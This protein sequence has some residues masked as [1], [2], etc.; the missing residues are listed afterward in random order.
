MKEPMISIIIPAYNAARTLPVLI[1]SVMEQP[2][3]NIEVIVVDDGSK[4]KTSEVVN[5][6]VIKNKRVILLS[7]SNQGVSAARNAG[8]RMARGEYMVFLDADDSIKTSMIEK[9]VNAVQ[10][11]RDSLVVCGVM[12]GDKEVLPSC[13][14]L[15]SRDVKE[16]VVAAILKN[17]L[18]Y[19][20]CN[21]IFVSSVIKEN[22]I[23]F[24]TKVKYGEDLIFNL[25]YLQYMS[26]VYYLRE[27]LYIYNHSR[28]GSSATSAVLGA[29]R[30][31]MYS[32]LRKY[33]GLGMQNFRMTM[34]LWLIR[35]RWGLSVQKARMKKRIYG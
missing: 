17:G 34:L 25:S 21:K 22:N 1:D 32:A 23:L 12:I 20:P 30:K 13:A 11:H 27:P 4:D 6:Y 31:V 10:K 18:L 15:I 7:Q 2:Y 14:G 28:D 29:Y 19:S 5:K 3:K 35:M 33:V 26:S 8:I 9:M 24:D 16:H